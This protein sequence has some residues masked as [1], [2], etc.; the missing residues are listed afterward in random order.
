MTYSTRIFMIKTLKKNL[1]A[2][3]RS[4]PTLRREY[5][6]RHLGIFGS[7]ARGVATKKSDI[8]ILIEF[9]KPIGFFKFVRLERELGHLLGRPVDLV[10][11][12]ALKPAIKRG[13]LKDVR[14]V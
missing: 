5:Q 8:D 3:Q 1:A 14:Y 13:I 9:T 7:V 2:L 6:V 10:T 11:K 4:L 12:R